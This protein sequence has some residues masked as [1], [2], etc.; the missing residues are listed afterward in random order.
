MQPSVKLQPLVYRSFF[1]SSLIP[2][3]V[4]ELLLLTL[5]FSINAYFSEKTRSTLI[6][7]VTLSLNEI[8]ANEALRVNLQLQAVSRSA[9]L[10]QTSH[11]QFFTQAICTLPHGEPDFAVH[12]NGAMYKTNAVG[13]SLYYS[14][15]TPIGEVQQQ[16]ARCSEALD[17]LLM[18][19]V[20]TN[21]AIVQAYIN[22]WDD[23]NRL[24]PFMDDAPSQYGPEIDMEAFNFYYDADAEHNPSRGPVWTEVYLDP[25]GQGW[26]L[27]SLVPIYN[28]EVLE[29]VSGIDVTVESFIDHVL[30]HEY[31]WRSASFVIDEAGTILA[32][33]PEAERLLGLTELKHHDYQ[34]SVTDTVTKPDSFQ[35]AALTTL[36]SDIARLSSQP[37]QIELA[38][39]D[40]LVDT[41]LIEETGWKIITLVDM[42]SFLSPVISL[43]RFSH[44]LG[45]L[46]VAIMVLFYF[47]FF[48]YLQY[49]S[50]RLAAEI[51]RPIE[52]LTTATSKLGKHWQLGDLVDTHVEEIHSLNRNF[53]NLFDELKSRTAELVES[54]INVRVQMREKEL[55]AQLAHTDTLTGMPNRLKLDEVL[56]HHHS[57]AKTDTHT[58]SVL[59]LDIDH[60]K[61]VNDTYGHQTGDIVLTELSDL[62]TQNVR[63]TDIVGRWG[64]EEFLVICS[65]GDPATLS[66][67]AERLREVVA[68]FSFT[69]IP[70]LTISIGVARY[71]DGD[72]INTLLSRADHAL[73]QAKDQGRNRVVL[74]SD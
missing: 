44:Q 7:E 43:T 27:S 9:Q 30:S 63:D 24:Y 62:L 16:K 28:G 22:T 23:M 50:K 61:R 4:I 3:L 17:P 64:G 69:D 10:L 60:F 32:M 67:L 41:N 45:Y 20:D 21:P 33:Q 74:A 54:T 55:L 65:G 29:G 68:T 15:S 72:D 2:L 5:Y 38:G 71:H 40:Y 14:R 31:P 46:A 12:A 59:L 52:A 18:T 6:E 48:L 66:D 58:Y 53:K 42:A 34:A 35:L 37:R 11:Q 19:I 56:Q 36:P 57:K 49:K 51:S 26:M 47:A 25:A 8:T 70:A 13:A 1:R 73:Y 39:H